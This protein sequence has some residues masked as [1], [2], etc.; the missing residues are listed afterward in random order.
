MWSLRPPPAHTAPR[1]PT[2]AN[3]GHPLR[4][5]RMS[6]SGPQASLMIPACSDRNAVFLSVPPSSEEWTFVW[7]L[8]GGWQ[9][10]VCP[11]LAIG[12]NRSPSEGAISV[13][14]MAPQPP[15]APAPPGKNV[16]AGERSGSRLLPRDRGPNKIDRPESRR[17]D[18]L[19]ASRP[20]A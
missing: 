8:A 11:L 18:A 4:I 16:S 1:R 17:S 9:I 12:R 3:S 13:A 5:V 14:R 2:C 7:L 15:R 20:G 6:C 10:A 19:L